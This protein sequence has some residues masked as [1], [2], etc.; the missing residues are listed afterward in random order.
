MLQINWIAVILIAIANMI[1]GFAWY[2]KL[3]FAEPWMKEMGIKMEDMTKGPGMGYMLTIVVSLVSGA[4]FSLIGHYLGLA[5]AVDGLFFGLLVWIGF[6]APAFAANYVF[7][8]K[9]FR[10]FAINAGYFLATS[11]V[12]GLIVGMIR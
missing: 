8:M 3:L 12:A 11:L 5:T 7:S 2:S 10:L 6:I 4:V 9:T 1:I